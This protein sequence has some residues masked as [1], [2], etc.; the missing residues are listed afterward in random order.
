MKRTIL[1]LIGIA[2]MALVA[3]GCGEESGVTPTPTATIGLTVAFDM[4]PP[5]T[6]IPGETGIETNSKPATYPDSVTVTS[7][8]LMVR[9]VRLNESVDTSVDTVITAA[10][11]N[12]DLGDAS[13]RFQGPYVVT[14]DG[15]SFN[16]G[17]TKIPENNYRQLTFVLQKAR[18][19]D[20]LN[21]YDELVGSSLTVRGKVWRD[22]EGLPFN[23]QTDYTSEF[24]VTGNFTVDAAAGGTVTVEFAPRHWFHTGSHWLDPNEP[25]NQLQIVRNIR[26]SVSGSLSPAD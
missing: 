7:G 19:T 18:S 17:T 12:R 3:A 2:A 8:L 21:G 25:A 9:S 23:Y 6:T 26:R 11:E 10:D 5:T 14:V 22:G 15:L 4:T 13:V 24:A 1:T 20:D 16:L